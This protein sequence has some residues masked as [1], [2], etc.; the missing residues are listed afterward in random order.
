MSHTSI[1]SYNQTPLKEI[2]T[3]SGEGIYSF[4]LKDSNIDFKT[5]SSFGKEWTKFDHF[6]E[7]EISKAGD[8][9]FDI[10]DFNVIGQQSLVLDVGCGTGRWTKY[11]AP[12][13]KFVEAID[14]SESIF[15]AASLLRDQ[16]NVR[17]TQASTDNIPFADN[18]F[19]L[20]F[21]IGVLHHIPDTQQAMQDC[22]KKVK[23]GGQFLVYLY[24]NLD[25]RSFL[26]KLIFKL[27]NLIRKVVSS[28]P[29]KLK[30]F[31]CDF[32]AIVLYMPF[33][34]LARLFYKLG[35]NRI[36]HKIPL[37]I[38]ANQSFNIIRNDSLDRFGT[39]L[40]QRFSR[41]QI[42]EMMK[43]SGLTDIVFSEKMPYW[44][45]TGKKI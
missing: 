32:L 16:P 27:S 4:D 22:V 29:G 44:H 2:K 15:S 6:S 11:I 33:V 25:N 31:V 41:K 23:K 37:A 17:I 28:L 45:A 5:V 30:R 20:V 26:F 9:Y 34:L 39:P 3:E 7:K 43:N 24:Y 13:V 14:P 35:L 36:A 10:V 1:L 42:T 8:M 40:E 19:D 38:Y 21:S 12:R 18:T